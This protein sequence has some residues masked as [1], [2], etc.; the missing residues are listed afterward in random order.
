MLA[1]TLSAIDILS[2]FRRIVAFWR[3]GEKFGIKTFWWSTILGRERDRDLGPEYAGLV[4]EDP[5]EF[6][7]TKISLSPIRDSSD[8]GPRQ[9][10]DGDTAQW[11]NDV[12]QHQHHP[13]RT[14]RHYRQQSTASDGTLFG[15]SSPMRSV[16]TIREVKGTSSKADLLFRISQGVFAVLERS[17]V[18]AG[19]VQVL[20]GIVTYT[21][22]STPW[23]FLV[24]VYT[25]YLGG[26][27]ENYE[28]GCLAH[29]ISAQFF[30]TQNHLLTVIN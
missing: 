4:V 16:D 19:L 24:N 2:L 20:T 29:L 6:E 3:S 26:C 27:R 11:A 23:F 12:H 14:H 22:T 21:G 13:R 7:D 28:N 25:I 15:T 8:L 30:N 1:L 9:E 17:L 18:F 10:Y 5:E